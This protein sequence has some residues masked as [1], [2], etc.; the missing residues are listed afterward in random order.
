VFIRVIRGKTSRWLFFVS[1]CLCGWKNIPL[2]SS[3]PWCYNLSV[4]SMCFADDQFST[5]KAAA[6]SPPRKPGRNNTP[7]LIWF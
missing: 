3:Q 6:R 7:Y 2:R 1:L 5:G 4:R